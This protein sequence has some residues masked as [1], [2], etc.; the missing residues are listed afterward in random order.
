MKKYQQGK[1]SLVLLGAA[2]AVPLL[3]AGCSDYDTNDY[4]N[5]KQN[6]TRAGYT[7]LEECVK[8]WN[9]ADC[10]RNPNAPST[11]FNLTGSFGLVKLRWWR[12]SL[13]LSPSR[14]IAR[15]ALQTSHRFRANSVR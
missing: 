14:C 8:D 11:A 13:I 9:S 7:S 2:V 10:E 12:L 3:V 6:V 1:V 4:Y 5:Q 15:T